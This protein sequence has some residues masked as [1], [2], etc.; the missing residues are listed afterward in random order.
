MRESNMCKAEDGMNTAF[1]LTIR[2]IA[3]PRSTSRFM[4][5]TC[6]YLFFH[7]RLTLSYIFKKILRDLQPGLGR[8]CSHCGTGQIH[9]AAAEVRLSSFC[10]AKFLIAWMF[11]HTWWILMID[12]FYTSWLNL[13]AST[14]FN[15]F[16]VASSHF[17]SLWRT[18]LISVRFACSHLVDLICHLP[19]LPTSSLCQ[20]LSAAL[21]VA[22]SIYCAYLVGAP[23][24]LAWRICQTGYRQS[25]NWWLTARSFAKLFKFFKLFTFLYI[26][27][28]FTFYV[29]YSAGFRLSQSSPVVC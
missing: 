9:G 20:T 26:S 6:H 15:S 8:P 25:Q 24:A 3:I 4:I 19:H 10:W 21:H 18:F 12:T 27:L 23:S 7:K 16:Q 13:D 29:R 5:T 28:L 1:G 22:A 11:E 14:I 2:F 17:K